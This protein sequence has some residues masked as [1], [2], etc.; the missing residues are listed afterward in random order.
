MSEWKRLRDEWPPQGVEILVCWMCGG[1]PRVDKAHT[2][3]KWRH[4]S[5]PRGYLIQG[6]PGAHA[7]VTHWM[8]LP[9]PPSV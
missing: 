6:Y 7:D 5:N 1:E 3:A 8:P 4:P 2:Y 9:Q